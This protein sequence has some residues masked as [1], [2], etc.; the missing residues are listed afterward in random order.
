MTPST[1]LRV[2]VAGAS[3]ETGRSIMNGLLVG[4]AHFD[5]IALVRPGGADKAVYRDMVRAGVT[6]E[7]ADYYNMEA[8]AAVLAGVDVVISCLL[9]LQRIE[10]ET[11][12]DAAHRASVG[13]FIP[14]FFSPIIPPRGVMEVRDLREDLLD[15]CKRLYLPYT[16]I[17]VGVWYQVSLPSPYAPLPPLAEEFIGDGTTPYALIDKADIGLYVARIITDSRTLNRSVF[18]YGELTTQN[19]VWA[20]VEAALGKSL[21]RDP[22]S[23]SD[24]ENRISDLQKSAAASPTS[25]GP[26]LELAMSQYR[27]SRCVRGDNTPKSAHYLGYLDGKELYPDLV[28]KTLRDFVREVVGGKCDHRVY[29]G[30]DV[31]ADAKIRTR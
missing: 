20:E 4:S 17:D 31:V 1:K 23:V 2:A 25:V 22:L 19:A 10:S 26:I 18:A 28:C 11:L 29:V 12:I 5:V 21:P 8:L 9:P 13:R 7:T 6:L 16:A 30:R 14:S 27:Y 15:R 24:L 3:G